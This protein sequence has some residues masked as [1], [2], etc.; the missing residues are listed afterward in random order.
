VIN[1]RPPYPEQVVHRVVEEIVE[2]LQAELAV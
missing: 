1:L 2:P